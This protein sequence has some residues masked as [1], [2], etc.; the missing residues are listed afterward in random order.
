MVREDFYTG[1]P[2]STGSPFSNEF[3]SE[4][5]AI[6]NA[7]FGQYFYD[8]GYR[9]P[10]QNMNPV[11]GF[12]YNPYMNM[13]PPNPGY[14]G[15]GLGGGYTNPAIA[16]KQQ[17]MQLQAAQE[18]RA[19][20]KPVNFGG[21]EFLPN[22]GFEETIQNLAVD[23]WMKEQEAE[24][25]QSF[26]TVPNYSYN[27]YVG[28]NN[29]YGTPYFQNTFYQYN[30]LYTEMNQK[31]EEMKE[32]AR[33]N[34]INLNFHLSKLVHNWLG[35]DYNEESL[36]ERFTGKYVTVPGYETYADY[37][38]QQ[39]FENLVPFDNSQM[40]RDYDKKVSDEFHAII[41]ENA[42]MEETFLNMGVVAAQYAME[43]ERHRRRDG[44][45]LYNA[46]DNS[47]KYFVRVKA[48]ERYAEKHGF[49]KPNQRNYNNN[50]S[51]NNNDQFKNLRKEALDQ[52]P[53]LSQ[54][55]SLSEDGTLNITCNFGSKAGQVYS[56]HNSQEAGYEEDRNRFQG[57]LDSIYQSVYSNSPTASG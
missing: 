29:Y 35:D 56:V 54:S 13:N 5:E 40:Y 26:T 42:G 21:S 11:G 3:I 17:M 50:L 36:K 15:Y 7:G 24:V 14:P 18:V 43:E 44:G 53:T 57:F 6:Q 8:P 22:V 55:A 31:I 46:N 51:I 45:N 30:P 9:Q 2:E 34:R 33:Q 25:K 28:F 48:A 23:Y 39:R 16:Y 37:Y 19:F 4:Q 27:P 32:E 20:I 41:P 49:Q 38:N 10:I 47:Y 12:G 52:F 1:E